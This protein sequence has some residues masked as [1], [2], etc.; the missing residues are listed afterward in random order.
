MK[1]SS[2]DTSETV[3]AREIHENE[4]SVLSEKWLLHVIGDHVRGCGGNK[5]V[6]SGLIATY[7][8]S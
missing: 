7:A 8:H 5:R 6:C 4:L 3:F 1:L 2:M